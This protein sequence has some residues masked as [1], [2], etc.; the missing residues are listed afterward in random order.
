MHYRRALFLLIVVATLTVTTSVQA[1]ENSFAVKW[2]RNGLSDDDRDQLVA[3]AKAASFSDVAG[4]LVRVLAEPR[5]PAIG[6]SQSKDPDRPWR[7]ARLTTPLKREQM[8][9][10]VWRHH[11]ESATEAEKERILLSV[12]RATDEQLE[13]I[14]VIN[15]LY[16]SWSPDVETELL[17]L[18]TNE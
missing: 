13:R 18:T 17:G 4:F 1:Q 2:Y 9:S 6:Y 16:C 12:L 8:A 11:M 5:Y 7:A 14:Y 15:R 10:A 3:E